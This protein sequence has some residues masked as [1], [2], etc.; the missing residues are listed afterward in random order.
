[1]KSNSIY[2]WLVTPS[3][4]SWSP[5]ALCYLTLCFSSLLSPPFHF[6]FFPFFLS[7]YPCFRSVSLFFFSIHEYL[8]LSSLSP[9][10]SHTHTLLSYWVKFH[11][12]SFYYDPFL[13][14]QKFNLF[15]ASLSHSHLLSLT[16]Q[17][18]FSYLPLY[19]EKTL[20]TLVLIPIISLSL[21]H[22]YT[23]S[24]CFSLFF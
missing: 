14:H 1:M 6:S 20:K 24:H 12:R 7:F 18:F 16:S 4:G 2:S 23:P 5:I 10:L 15:L 17:F 3:S 9:S 19:F 8:S 21:L 11:L 13:I 22:T